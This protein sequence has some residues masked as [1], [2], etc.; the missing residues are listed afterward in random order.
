MDKPCECEWCSKKILNGHAELNVGNGVVKHFC[1]LS[2]QVA[3]LR[4][5]KLHQEGGNA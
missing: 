2:H 5:V 4:W 1:D 3:Y